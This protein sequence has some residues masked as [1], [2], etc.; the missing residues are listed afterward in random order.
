M[1]STKVTQ[2][3]SVR[4]DAAVVVH[5]AEESNRVVFEHGKIIREHETKNKC[6]KEEGTS[7]EWRS[8]C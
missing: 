2:Q 7:I 4:D 3:R 6:E 5:F 1:T 8:G